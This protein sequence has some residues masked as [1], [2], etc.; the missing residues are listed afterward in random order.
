M[1]KGNSSQ[2]QPSK[3]GGGSQ[4]GGN[5]NAGAAEGSSISQKQIEKIVWGMAK[6]QA[7]NYPTESRYEKRLVTE[8]FYKK[9]MDD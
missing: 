9:M 8:H 5:H 7:S 2:S 1:E 6:Q 3:S 4:Q